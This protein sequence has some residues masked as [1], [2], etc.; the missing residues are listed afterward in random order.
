M[1]ELKDLK[2]HIET[3]NSEAVK[4]LMTEFDLVEVNGKLTARDSEKAKEQT[5]FWN[6]R[7]QARK[8]LLNTY[9]I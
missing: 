7:Q 4:W 2:K 3:G 1:Y 6:Q 9:F 8:I 5:V